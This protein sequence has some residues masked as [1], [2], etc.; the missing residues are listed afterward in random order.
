M[1]IDLSDLVEKVEWA[2]VHEDEARQI[3]ETGMQF[4]QRVLT[5]AQNDCYFAAVL[6]E[7]ARLQNYAEKAVASESREQ[8]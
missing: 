2:I 4:A 8:S 6:L 1:K 5:D 3:Q 7:W